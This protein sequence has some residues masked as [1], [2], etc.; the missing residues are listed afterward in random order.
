MAEF[1]KV[2]A[3]R[4]ARRQREEQARQKLLKDVHQARWEQIMLKEAERIK[5]REEL[6]AERE[7]VAAEVAAAQEVRTCAD[8]ESRPARGLTTAACGR[9]AGLGARE[10][11]TAACCEG[12]TA[13]HRAGQAPLARVAGPKNS[14]RRSKS[15]RISG[16]AMRHGLPRRRNARPSPLPRRSIANG[17][18]AMPARS[19]IAVDRRRRLEGELAAAAA[20]L[21][22]PTSARTRTRGTLH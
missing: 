8:A 6:F 18:L 13:R 10:T 14:P 19:I 21:P 1:E 5:Q 16:C 4:E 11:A 7:R 22:K 17:G 9:G 3:T 12:Q 20:P 15:Q 2:E